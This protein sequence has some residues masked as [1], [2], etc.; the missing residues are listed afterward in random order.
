MSYDL[1]FQEILSCISQKCL[2]SL[3]I[4]LIFVNLQWKIIDRRILHQ[5]WETAQ[6]AK[7]KGIRSICR[8]GIRRACTQSEILWPDPSVWPAEP[9]KVSEQFLSER[10]GSF[11]RLAPAKIPNNRKQTAVMKDSS[12]GTLTIQ[13]KAL[14]RDYSFSKRRQCQSCQVELFPAERYTGDVESGRYLFWLLPIILSGCDKVLEV[15][16]GSFL[17]YLSSRSRVDLLHMITSFF[18][19]SSQR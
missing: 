12:S 18:S 1:L 15:R 19:P 10:S 11:R 5:V 6:Y 8:S 14:F 16:K 17:P 7:S 2:E 13:S 9:V 3:F 4:L